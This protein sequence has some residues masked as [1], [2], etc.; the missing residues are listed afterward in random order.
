MRC[1]TDPSLVWRVL[2]VEDAEAAAGLRAACE[3]VDDMGESYSAEDFVDDL[4]S[5]SIDTEL[6]TFGAF[7]DGR[8]VAMAALHARTAADPVHEMFL[9]GAVHPDFRGRGIGARLLAWGDETAPVI[10]GQ[11]FPGVPVKLQSPAFDKMAEHRALLEEHGYHAEHYD[12]GMQRRISADEADRAPALPE[13]FAVVPFGPDVAEEFRVTHN[14]AFVPDHPGSTFLPPEVFAE[15]IGSASFRADLTFGLR[16]VDSGAL[17]GYL[18]CYYYDADTK[19]TG[20]RDVYINYLGTRREFRGQGVAGGLIATVVHAGAGQ[21]F[22]TV[23]LGVLAEN[24]TGALNVYRR[25][26][27]EVQRTFITYVKHLG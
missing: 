26:G 21:G 22:D 5:S 10:S 2:T 25:A 1:M 12:F 13:G 14:E 20:L 27:F 15:R 9:W 8:L 11:R 18:L 16:H 17:A 6:G 3:A 24:P 19:A 4:T 7:A 23:S